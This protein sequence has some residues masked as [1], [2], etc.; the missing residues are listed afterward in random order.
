MQFPPF[1]ILTT[2][3]L[4]LRQVS[5]DDAPTIFFLRSDEIVNK[6]IKRARI[7]Q[8]D[9][10]FAFIHKMNIGFEDNTVIDWAIT[11]KENA[12]MIG[13]VCLWN[14]SEDRTVA[15]LGY[16]MDTAYQGNGFMNEAIRSVIDYAFNKLS[17]IK[18]EAFT[19]CENANSIKLLEKIGFKLNPGRVDENNLANSIY[20][21]NRID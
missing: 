6:F 10:A 19:N 13:R 17:V 3:R 9:E 2:E 5:D 12:V 20:S 16:E 7:K 1:P 8:M 4:I 18:I 15:E 21:L 14:F 11:L